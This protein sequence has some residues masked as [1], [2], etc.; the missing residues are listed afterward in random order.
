MD[1][2]TATRD[3]NSIIGAEVA[4]VRGWRAGG[5]LVRTVAPGAQHARTVSPP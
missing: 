1:H 4:Q 5:A 3:A 2:R